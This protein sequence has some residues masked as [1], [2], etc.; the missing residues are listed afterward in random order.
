MLGRIVKQRK[1][2]EFRFRWWFIVLIGCQVRPH[3]EGCIR[4]DIKELSHS[5]T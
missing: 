4:S 5:D 2:N 1:E 3:Q